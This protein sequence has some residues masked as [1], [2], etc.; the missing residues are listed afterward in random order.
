MV[1]ARIVFENL[2]SN[3]INYL[4]YMTRFLGKNC[5]L[6]GLKREHINRL[7]AIFSVVLIFLSVF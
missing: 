3:A 2:A 6:L 5:V 7:I 1:I 4:L